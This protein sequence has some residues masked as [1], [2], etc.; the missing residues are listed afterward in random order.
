MK[1]DDLGWKFKTLA[2][3]GCLGERLGRRWEAKWPLAATI[4]APWGHFGGSWAAFGVPL[5][6]S[7]AD[8]GSQNGDQGGP[9]TGPRAIWGYNGPQIGFGVYFWGGFEVEKRSF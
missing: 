4:L 8:F 5:G 3:N 1:F 9:Q 7:W 2:E 6:C